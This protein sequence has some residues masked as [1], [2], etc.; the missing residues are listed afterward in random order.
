MNELANGPYISAVGWLDRVSLAPVAFPLSEAGR[1]RAPVTFGQDGKRQLHAKLSE[2]ELT[3][4]LP[5]SF[6]RSS[7]APRAR[8]AARSALFAANLAQALCG[9]IPRRDM[10]SD[11][12]AVSVAASFPT[13]ATCLEFETGGVAHGWENANTM[14]LPSSILSAVS[15]QLSGALGIHAAAVT[16]TNGIFGFCCAVEHAHLLF[17]H[18]RADFCLAIGAEEVCAAQLEAMKALRVSGDVIDGASGILLSRSAMPGS[19]RLR[20]CGNHAPGE[21]FSLPAEWDDASRLSIELTDDDLFATATLA[22]FAIWQLAAG[23]KN[24]AVFQCVAP[25]LGQFVLGFE[26]N[27]PCC[28][29]TL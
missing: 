21:S 19:W 3:A 13:A 26:K 12:V 1:Q 2:R 16:F 11:D 27:Q 29:G 17:F 22:P 20:I 24:K 14:L 5:A 7:K 28:A 18:E 25:A 6:L 15:T 4:D 10:I 9:F 8:Y 23:D